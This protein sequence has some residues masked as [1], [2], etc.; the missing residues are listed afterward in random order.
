MNLITSI[1]P[2]W[3]DE[4]TKRYLDT[5]IRDAVAKG[6]TGIHDAYGAVEHVKF[7]EK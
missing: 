6:V 7:Y 4:Q 5:T 2:P 3:T 1:R